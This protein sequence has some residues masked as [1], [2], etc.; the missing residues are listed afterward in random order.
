MTR[1]SLCRRL[2]EPQGRSGRVRNTLLL[3]G[4][5]LRTV[6]PLA[7]RYTVYAIQAQIKYYDNI[8]TYKEKKIIEDFSG[9]ILRFYQAISEVLCMI[10]L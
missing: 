6:Q 2:G 10:L 8:I 4:F 5:D 3:P 1:Y 7:I 9:S